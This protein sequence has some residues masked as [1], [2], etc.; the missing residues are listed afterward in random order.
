MGALLTNSAPYRSIRHRCS[1]CCPTSGGGAHTTAKLRGD[2]VGAR[3]ASR[4][5]IAVISEAILVLTFLNLLPPSN[6]AA[7]T[8]PFH[9]DCANQVATKNFSSIPS[10]CDT[11]PHKLTASPLR[12]INLVI[13]HSRWFH[14]GHLALPSCYGITSLNYTLSTFKYSQSSN[15]LKHLG[16]SC[17]Q[18]GDLCS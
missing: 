11:S 5:C 2:R 3:A 10:T 16:H 4:H 17:S 13:P 12:S 7:Y 14:M 15:W 18:D 1:G 9:L 6:G 8:T